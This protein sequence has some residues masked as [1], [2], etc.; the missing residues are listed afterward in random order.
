MATERL[1]MPW[2]VVGPSGVYWLGHADSEVSA[3]TIALGW[4]DADE[5]AEHKRAGWYAAEATA[6]WKRPDGTA[7]PTARL[8][9]WANR[10]GNVIC[11]MPDQFAFQRTLISELQ[12]ITSEMRAAASGVSEARH[13]T[14]SP[15]TLPTYRKDAP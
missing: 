2:V 15:D 7:R 13:Q 9:Q 14:S 4:P 1:Q 8:E 5:V 6:T 11:E 3:W 10:I 12:A